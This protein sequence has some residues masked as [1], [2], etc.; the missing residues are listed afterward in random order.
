MSIKRVMYIKNFSFQ[1]LRKIGGENNNI[2]CSSV[3]RPKGDS[4]EI[5]IV[6]HP[7]IGLFTYLYAYVFKR[8][9]STLVPREPTTV[10]DVNAQ[11]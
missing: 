1:E 8:A 11:T 6:C 2:I 4:S 10:D 3:L 5:Y 7:C 9:Y